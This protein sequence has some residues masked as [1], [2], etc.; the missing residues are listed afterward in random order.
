MVGTLAAGTDMRPD[1]GRDA[2]P[3]GISWPGKMHTP[4]ARKAGIT[5]S[6][7]SMHVTNA[8][9][10]QQERESSSEEETP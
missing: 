5:R 8:G 9:T 10:Q 2:P 1:P 6:R 7:A 4:E 3:A